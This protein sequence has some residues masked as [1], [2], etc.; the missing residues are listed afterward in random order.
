MSNYPD[1]IHDYD[2]H[3]SSPFYVEPDENEFEDDGPDY[4][5]EEDE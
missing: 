5:L 1:D 3:P 4:D 2:D